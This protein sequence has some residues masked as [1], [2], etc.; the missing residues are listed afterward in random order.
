ML[1]LQA[2]AFELR[3]KVTACDALYIAFAESVSLPLLTDDRKLATAPGHAADVHQHPKPGAAEPVSP[4]GCPGRPGTT[5]GADKSALVGCA[6]AERI[7]RAGLRAAPPAGTSTLLR[8]QEQ[9]RPAPVHISELLNGLR[10][11]RCL[12]RWRR[13]RR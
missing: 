9:R 2:R 4:L 13:W 3:Y 12:R 7:D 6:S 11:G 10:S 5:D 8:G 1:P